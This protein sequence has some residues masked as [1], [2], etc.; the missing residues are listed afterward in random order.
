MQL[1]QV[2]PMLRAFLDELHARVEAEAALLEGRE[3][4]AHGLGIEEEAPAVVESAAFV[5]GTPGGGG[6]LVSLAE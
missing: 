3:E 2:R 1:R 4:I 6:V 5:G